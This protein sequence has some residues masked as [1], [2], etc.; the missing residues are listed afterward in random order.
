MVRRGS[1]FGFFG[2]AEN[3]RGFLIGRYVIC[4]RSATIHRDDG[5]CNQAHSR[6]FDAIRGGATMH[7]ERTTSAARSGSRIISG[8]LMALALFVA[9]PAAAQDQ[10]PWPVKGKLLGAQ[11]EKSEDVSGIACA[12]ATG[13]PRACLLIDDDVQGAQVVIVK[14]GEITAAS[15]FR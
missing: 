3:L 2:G 5:G 12:S 15:L 14:H 7:V 13:F 4:R 1:K 6:T 10:A 8:L 9:A 11:G